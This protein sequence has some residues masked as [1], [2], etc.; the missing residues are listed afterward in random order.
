MAAGDG[1]RW[2]NYKG[3][4]KH[5]IEIDGEVLLHRTVKQFAKYSDVTVVCKS[6]CDDLYNVPGSS[7][8][9]PPEEH[10]W[11]EFAK[12]YCTHELWKDDPVY[13][14]FG[15]V[16]FTDDAVEKIMTSDKEL[17]FPLRPTGSERIKGRPEIFGVFF[18]KTAQQL[19]TSAMD[20]LI[21]GKVP[22]PAGWRIY[23]HLV[24]PNYDRNEL[25]VIIDDL[26]T[27]FDFPEDLD[28]WE[29]GR[30]LDDTKSLDM[31]D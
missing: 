6:D 12:Y 1:R 4:P 27:D 15:D 23:R 13:I 10:E 17:G 26:T 22:P 28:N 24:R 20:K 16:Y 30:H 19:L 9:S 2:G 11:G 3:T 29:L 31:I 8:W 5:L 25:Q 21:R 18:R 14:V 7:T